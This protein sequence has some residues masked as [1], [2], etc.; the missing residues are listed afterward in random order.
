MF[1]SYVPWWISALWISLM[2]VTILKL[3]RD[4]YPA[5]VASVLQPAT[6]RG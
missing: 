1:S 4:G 2:A 6:V 3:S 5:S